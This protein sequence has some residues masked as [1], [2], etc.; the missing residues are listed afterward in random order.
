MF[1]MMLESCRGRKTNPASVLQSAEQNVQ[2]SLRIGHGAYS[3]DSMNTL[4][5]THRQT[6]QTTQYCTTHIPHHGGDVLAES[7]HDAAD[8]RGVEPAAGGAHH[9]VDQT[10]VQVLKNRQQ[11]VA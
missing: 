5:K 6:Q 8:G 4:E 10:P 11:A 3:A 2:V 1:L 9:A 7:V